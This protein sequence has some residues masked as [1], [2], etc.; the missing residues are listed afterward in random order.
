MTLE[1]PVQ[2]NS[3]NFKTDKHIKYNTMSIFVILICKYQLEGK[4]MP[5]KGQLDFLSLLLI[6]LTSLLIKRLLY[7]TSFYSVKMDHPRTSMKHNFVILNFYSDFIDNFCT[8]LK[9]VIISIYI[10][11]LMLHV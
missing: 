3:I 6:S 5:V 1:L 11:Q 7:K 10:S 4:R 8:I 2:I 9:F